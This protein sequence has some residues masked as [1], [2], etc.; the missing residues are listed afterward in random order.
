MIDPTVGVPP[1]IAM[2][3]NENF[4][5]SDARAVCRQLKSMFSELRSQAR[6][7]NFEMLPDLGNDP[8]VFRAVLSGGLDLF[9]RDGVC[10]AP[11]CRIGYATRISR[12]IALMADQVTMHDFLRETILDLKGRPTNA[13]LERLTA[14]VYVL[15]QLKPLVRE[16]LLRFIAPVLPTCVSCMD[17]F[18][19]RVEVLADAVI[20]QTDGAMSVERTDEYTAINTGS[21]FEPPLF[22]RFGSR[23]AEESDRGLIKMMA[24][25]AVRFALWDARDA[26][27]VSGAVFSNS[28]SGLRGLLTAEG[29]AGEDFNYREFEGQRAAELPWVNGLT[30]EQTI[31]LRH[32]AS[33]ALP[34]LREFLARRLAARAGVA[35]ADGWED[36]V[37][38]LREQAEEVRAELA[39]AT[40]RSG[41]LRRNASGILGLGISALGFALEGPFAAVGTLLSTLGLTHNHQ[42]S[43][44][45]GVPATA[46]PGF[47]LVVARDILGHARP[48]D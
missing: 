40:R 17:E 31:Q 28:R 36:C 4:D 22:V 37:A 16:G 15:H 41:A 33:Q 20:Q 47:V 1:H 48:E 3:L 6:I 10:Q 5:L 26:S 45:H 24:I 44:H 38:E 2:L 29:L 19:R 25:R 46:K 11:L 8:S 32:E 35:R 23:L 27:M 42:Q 30:V 7:A 14:D 43:Q 18:E 39:Q 12:S 13:D 9:G 21:M 34:S